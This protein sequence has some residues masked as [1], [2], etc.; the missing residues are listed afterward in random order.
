MAHLL[1]R[2]AACAIATAACSSPAFA[3]SRSFVV[4]WF[5]PAFF[6]DAGGVTE[7]GS[8]CPKGPNP[9]VNK[10]QVLKTSY[11]T[12][13][14]IDRL[15]DPE[16]SQWNRVGGIR[17]PNKE[18]VYEKPWAVPD[19]KTMQPV[20]GKTSHGFDLDGDNSNGF[21]DPTG[22][23]GIDNNY[24][25]MAGC[26]LGW[27]GP[28]RQSHH[29][30]YVNDGMRD[31]V[32]SVLIVVSG[33]GKDPNNDPD[34]RIGFYMSRD[35]MVK[36][37]NGEI[38]AD[39]TFRVNTDPRFQSMANAR[40]RNGVIESVEPADLELRDVETAPFFEPQLKLYRAQFRFE[41]HGRN[42]MTGY[43]GG[44]RSL[45]HYFTGWAAAGAVHESVT[46]IDIPAYWYGLQKYA[47]FKSTPA[48][49]KPD[50]ISTAY[51]FFLTPA[52]VATPDG[53]KALTEVALFEG[54]IDEKL[55]RRSGMRT[56]AAQRQPAAVAPSA[57]SSPAGGR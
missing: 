8:D 43:M 5:E 33:T 15:L 12:W 45:D 36:D 55:S 44:Y 39:Y 51:R 46:H 24:Y 28:E 48:A 17:G 56:A 25:R 54:E 47:D 3:W 31:G 10:R 52:F 40:V 42:G 13:P 49:E 16:G 26:W 7:P 50:A 35:K 2:I 30:K 22:R 23:T 57:A 53:K 32:L 6:F 34:A 37:G 27:R 18:N 14:E 20:A 4:E 21:T 29:A 19:P 9:S 38:T 11:R 1:A 41:P